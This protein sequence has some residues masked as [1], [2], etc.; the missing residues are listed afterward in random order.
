VSRLH[1][2]PPAPLR[3]AAQALL[4]SRRCRL[5]TMALAHAPV[6]CGAN[7]GALFRENLNSSPEEDDM[8]RV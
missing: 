8:V 7:A 3:N 1:L 6:C 5:R 2:L 4:L